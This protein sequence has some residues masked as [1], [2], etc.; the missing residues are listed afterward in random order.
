MGSLLNILSYYII[1][2]PISLT[3]A[4]SYGQGIFGLWWGMCFGYFAC[5]F[6]YSNLILRADWKKESQVAQDRVR[7]DLEKLREGSEAVS[8]R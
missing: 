7:A 5:A 3:L 1:G 6:L 4:F 8:G 2:V